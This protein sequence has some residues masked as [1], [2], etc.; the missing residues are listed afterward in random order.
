[1]TLNTNAILRHVVVA[2]D[3]HIVGN[4]VRVEKCT[5]TGNIL[6]KDTAK[7]SKIRNNRFLLR[8]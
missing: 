5:I 1:M 2:G 8:R 6:V 4:N 7:N 3:V